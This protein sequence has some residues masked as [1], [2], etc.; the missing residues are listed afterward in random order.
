[1]SSLTNKAFKID[2]RKL[3]VVFITVLAITGF[4]VYWL[5]DSY[6]REQKA[7][8]IK[9]NGLFRETAMQVQDSV[10]QRKITY[11]TNDS[12]KKGIVTRDGSVGFVQ[13]VQPDQKTAKAASLVLQKIRNDSLKKAGEKKSNVLVSIRRQG[14]DSIAGR[15]TELPF[16][17]PEDIREVVV[18]NSKVPDSLRIETELHGDRLMNR[19][20]GKPSMQSVNTL[21][22]NDDGGRQII[23]KVDSLYSDSLSIP[24]LTREL[25]KALKAENMDVPFVI[26][27][28]TN[29]STDR[30]REDELMGPRFPF[31]FFGKYSLQLGN[32]FS[33]LIKKIKLPIVFSVL[34]IGFTV[35]SFVV[36]YRSLLKQQ[37]LADMKN[38]FMSNITHE[39]KTPIATVGVA[40]E[41]LRNF[42][43]G[44]SP[45]RT[46]EYLD[47]S[48]S[49]LQRLSLLVDKVLKLSLFE[50]KE[51]ELRKENIDLREIVHEVTNIMKLQFEKNNAVVTIETSGENFMIDA[52]R[53][54]ITSV[55]YNLL[56]NALKYSK[57]NPVI[58]ISL[59][60]LPNDIVEL[61]ISDNGIGIPREYRWKV[62]DKFFRVPSGNTHNVK[63]Y[64]LGLSYVSEI[65]KRH[66]GFIAVESEVGSGAVFTIK[67]P[68]KEADVIHFDD[69]R[70]MYR[71]AI[72]VDSI[73]KGKKA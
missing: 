5:R 4:Q 65:I 13:T 27:V 20:P 49:E 55:I 40:I 25:T 66:M 23:I 58:G 44:Q 35:F 30:H 53:L 26:S 71:K 36:L 1:M 38:E 43:A 28:R 32:S 24:Q 45:E 72:R 64:G 73:L 47:I 61:K 56:D 31:G 42:G 33:Y 16:L 67:I 70:K 14:D 2:E 69:N 62:F 8:E 22:F 18:V 17:H 59:S 63:G 12:L 37:R 34:L 3:L 21:Y 52:D 9:V 10:W 50:N 46:K 51:V 19:H 60:A 48:A 6:F 15:K 11:V 39:L 54:H 57:E 41:A 68:R 29:D 7:L